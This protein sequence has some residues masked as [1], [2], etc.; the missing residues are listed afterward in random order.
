ML[1]AGTQRPVAE[2]HDGG[3]SLSGLKTSR[4]LLSGDVS[5]KNGTTRLRLALRLDPDPPRPPR[6]A[7]DPVLST[8]PKAPDR[9]R[10]VVCFLRNFS[11]GF[12]PAGILDLDLIW[13]G[14]TGN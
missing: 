2:G 10:A 9:V 11:R 7:P 14:S 8:S 4:G 5:L 1:G 13:T 3:S 12:I 6:A